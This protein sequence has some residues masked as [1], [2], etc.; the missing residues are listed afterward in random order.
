MVEKA[1]EDALK[2]LELQNE[3]KRKQLN[4]SVYSDDVFA[5]ISSSNEPSSKTKN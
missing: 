3:E 1:V 4:Q 5:E 2:K